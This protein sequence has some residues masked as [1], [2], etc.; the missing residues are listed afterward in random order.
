[1]VEV[2]FAMI[3]LAVGFL[4]L[5]ALAVSSVRMVARAN[6][7]AEL[8]MVASQE[9]ELAFQQMRAGQTPQSRCRTVADFRV[10]RRMEQLDTRT[11]TVSVTASATGSSIP[12]RPV[13]LRSSLYTAYPLSGADSGSGEC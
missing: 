6:R 12:A 13:T 1:M 7:Q 10:S 3:L 9:M 5:Q 2:L 11:P 8:A 4:G